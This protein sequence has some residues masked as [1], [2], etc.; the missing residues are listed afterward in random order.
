MVAECILTH[1][2]SYFVK[3]AKAWLAPVTDTYEQGWTNDP[4]VKRR[5]WMVGDTSLSQNLM[6]RPLYPENSVGNPA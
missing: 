1:L 2:F 6:Q 5:G 3:I 4:G